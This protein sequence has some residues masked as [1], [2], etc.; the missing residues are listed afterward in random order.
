ML[1]TSNEVIRSIVIS[2]MSGRV[3]A[4][5]NNINAKTYSFNVEGLNAGVYHMQLFMASG[6]SIQRF[7]A[8]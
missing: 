8:E 5:E 6:V 3:I 4:S 2:D 1:V 7:I